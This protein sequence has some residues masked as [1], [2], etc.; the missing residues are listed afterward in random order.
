MKEICNEHM[1]FQECELA[2]VRAAVDKAEEVQ[3]R[4]VVRLPEVKKIINVVE[5]FLRKKQLICY[6]GTAINNILPKEDQFYNKDIEI[7]DYDFFSPSALKHAKELCDWY[8]NQGFLEVEAK[9]GV[10]HGTYKV[11]VNFMP[12]AD[13]TQMPRGLF[14]SLRASSIKVAGI[15][16]APP[17]YL[18]MAMYL[19]LS[20]PSGEVDRWEKVLKRLTLLNKHYHVTLLDCDNLTFQRQMSDPTNQEAIY[21]NVETTLVDQGAVFFGGYALSLYSQY[22]PKYLR[23]KL[24]HIPDFDVL[25][26]EPLETAQIVKERLQDI[27]ISNV[28]LIKHPGVGEIISPHYEIKV[29]EDAIAFIYEPLACHS[30]NVIKVGSNKL[31]IATIDTM[32]SFYLAFIYADRPYYSPE[33]IVCMAKFLFDVQQR[34][35]LAQKGLLKRFSISCVGK[36]LTM[37]EIRNEKAEK[38][39]ELKADRSNPEYEEWFLRYRPGDKKLAQIQSKTS[40]KKK[41]KK[42]YSKKSKKSIKRSKSKSKK[43]K[44]SKK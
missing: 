1:T 23:K 2:I 15:L 28:K 9:S 21:K 6:G 43:S 25:S 36:Q 19:E 33:R 4:R 40:S 11:Y 37:E 17:N 20:R 8:V 27:N 32:L 41:S 13:I 44:K 24:Q 42:S 39:K 18:R 3:G 30:Y 31:K 26:E 22:M 16:Y 35:R 14:D 10:H 29:G 38:F 7:P 5:K 12:V 34:N